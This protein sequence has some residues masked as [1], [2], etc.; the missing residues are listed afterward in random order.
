MDRIIIIGGVF[1]R[2]YQ[3][4]KNFNLS[5]RHN[6]NCYVY[7]FL[8]KK[9]KICKNIQPDLDVDDVEHEDGGDHEVVDELG[10]R[11]PGPGVNVLHKIS[12]KKGILSRK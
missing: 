12:K 1:S 10:D 4:K 7:H 3:K 8:V 6:P 9:S 5:S 2:N 11:P